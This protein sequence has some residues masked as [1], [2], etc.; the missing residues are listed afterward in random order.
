MLNPA[1]KS[2]PR[3]NRI[4]VV[5]FDQ[6]KYAEIIAELNIRGWALIYNFAPSNPLTI[7]KHNGFR[8]Q[9]ERLNKFRYYD[10]CLKNLLISAP[11]GGYRSPP[12]NPL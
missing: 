7:K 4:I 6:D 5:S 3:E 8:S 1:P 10:N 9:A 12:L 11:S 2:T